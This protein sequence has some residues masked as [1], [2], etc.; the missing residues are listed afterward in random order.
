M[1][2][3]PFAH[4]NMRGSFQTVPN[5]KMCSSR[6]RP[7]YR[8]SKYYQP[9]DNTYKTKTHL[10]SLYIK[11]Y[12]TCHKR[13]LQ[14]TTGSPDPVHSE[15]ASRHH[16]GSPDRG[17]SP[18]ATNREYPVKHFF[19][20]PKFVLFSFCVFCSLSSLFLKIKLDLES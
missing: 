18:K 10:Y 7:F 4:T 11:R 6:S 16:W 17:L 19:C 5:L 3:A 14:R 8:L 12:K 15:Q 2:M 20:R 13:L 1:I 9:Y